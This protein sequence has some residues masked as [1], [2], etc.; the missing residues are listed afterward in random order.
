VE[1]AGGGFNHSGSE[2]TS[3][4]VGFEV[5]NQSGMFLGS[6]SK[7]PVFVSGLVHSG[8]EE[9]GSPSM[10]AGGESQSGIPDSSSAGAMDAGATVLIQSGNVLSA[11][12]AIGSGAGSEGTN[13]A[14]SQSGRGLDG[15]STC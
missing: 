1:P 10:D 7:G 3:T 5:L 2:S 9:G 13:G 14:A 15:F 11:L 12:G 8:R 4:L 6:A